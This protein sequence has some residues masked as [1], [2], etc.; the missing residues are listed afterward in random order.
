M[1]FSWF[2]TWLRQRSAVSKRGPTA[3]W[4]GPALPLRV[5]WLEDRRLLAAGALDVTFGTAGTALVDIAGGNDEASAVVMQ[6]DGKL[7]FAGTAFDSSTN[8]ND[9]ALLRLNANGSLDTTFGT[10][11][12]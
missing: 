2:R 3:R 6:S 4:R 9:F 7:V 5:E 11:G 10:G 8:P 1:A 12:K